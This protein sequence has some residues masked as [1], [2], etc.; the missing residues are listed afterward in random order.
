MDT[1]GPAAEAL[2]RYACAGPP[3]EGLA[4]VRRLR[5]LLDSW[6]RAQ[7]AAARGEGWNWSEIARV[8][9][10]SRQAV[11]AKYRVEKPDDAQEAVEPARPTWTAVEQRLRELYEQSIT[12]AITQHEFK[13]QVTAVSDQ[14]PF[15]IVTRMVD[16]RVTE[17]M[18]STSP[19]ASTHGMDRSGGAGRRGPTANRVR[20]ARVQEPCD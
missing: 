6:E 20:L 7:V 9:G 16:N 3:A 17:L 19:P 18:G 5:D 12:G 4:A 8:L 1:N 10:R 2:A 14:L 15:R 11:H 13:R